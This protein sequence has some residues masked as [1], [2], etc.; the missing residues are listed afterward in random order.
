MTI[1]L[2]KIGGMYF[3]RVFRLQFSFCVVSKK[4]IKLQ[5]KKEE[6]RKRFI[7][8]LREANLIQEPVFFCEFLPEKSTKEF[9]S[10][11]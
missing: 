1:Y 10:F 5:K 2:K 7:N 4:T 3:V 11:Y 6:I 9:N 8:D